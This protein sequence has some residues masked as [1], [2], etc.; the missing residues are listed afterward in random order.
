[1]AERFRSA[2]ARDL[3]AAIRKAGGTVERVGVGKL[4]ITGPNGTVTVHEP[5]GESRRDLRR[6]SATRRIETGTGLTLG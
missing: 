5:S 6:S 3:V 1:M 4:R 2:V